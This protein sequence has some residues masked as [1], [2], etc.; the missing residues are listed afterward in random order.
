MEEYVS[1][2][3]GGNTFDLPSYYHNLSPIGH[4]SFGSVVSAKNI[5][6]NRIVA[7][8]KINSSLSNVKDAKRIL[9][10]IK[11][12]KHFHHDNI[13]DLIDIPLP[14]DRNNFKEVYLVTS[15]LETDLHQVIISPQPL[16]DKHIQYFL[17]QI[18]RG[19]KHIH[20]ANLLHR[21]LKPSN[22]LVNSNC[23][24]K[25]CDFG[26][27]RLAAPFTPKSKH[28]TSKTYTAYVATRWY[29]APEV[30]LSWKHYTYAIDMWSVGCIF[31]ELLSRQPMFQGNDY[32]NQLVRIFEKMGTPQEEDIN[33]IKNDHARSWIKSI[34]TIPGNPLGHYFNGVSPTALDLLSK[35]LTFNP[36]KRITVNDA[37]A[38]PYLSALH[39]PDEEPE[40]LPPFNFK[41]ESDNL[42]E[43]E[44]REL[45]F[46][47]ALSFHKVQNQ[48]DKNRE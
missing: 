35:M 23:S 22:L 30:I 19:L 44:F 25:I 45:L 12:L 10:E 33:Y 21:D 27:A 15:Y 9:R 26:M 38:H 43:V 41:F 1:H 2:S 18:L 34:G 17:Y 47:E 4:G 3:V 28:D 6:V 13:L 42:N 29:R 20:S 36:D 16:S 39:D 31:A 24:L 11:L 37:L 32:M 48:K 5:L 14:F 7:I 46:Q 8:K 40:A